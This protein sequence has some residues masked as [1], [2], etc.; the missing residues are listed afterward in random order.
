M[1]TPSL[2]NTAATT[3]IRKECY[4]WDNHTEQDLEQIVS[5]IYNEIVYFVSNDSSEL[6]T[7]SLKALMIMPALLLQKP[8]YKSKSKQHSACLSRH[9]KQW[10]KGDFDSL[11]FEAG[12]IQ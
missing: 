3:N 4:I 6:R 9:L 2:H 12:T 11:V 5:A 8:S 7:C 1:E 10:I